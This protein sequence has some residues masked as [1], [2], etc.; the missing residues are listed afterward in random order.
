MIEQNILPFK[1]EVS[2]ENLTAHA[3]LILAHEFH[4]GLA[5]DRLLDEHLPPPG[6]G[7]GHR[8]SEVILPTVLMLQGGGTDLEDI[9]VIGR[10]KTLRAA[11]KLERVPAST[12]LGD[13]L[14]RYGSSPLAMRGLQ[15][16]HRELTA[17]RLNAETRDD[18]TLDIDATIIE[19]HKTDATKAYDG[20]KGYHPMLGFL[21][22]NRWLLAD[23]FRTGSASPS[24]GLV[25]FIE[26]CRAQMPKGKR[27]ARLR[28]DSA[29]YN[30]YVVDYCEEHRIEYVI[31][32]AWD[33]SVKELYK[34]LPRDSWTRYVPSGSRREREVAETI[35]TFNLGPSSFRIIFVRDVDPQKELFGEIRGRAIVTNVSDE[36]MDAA[37]VVEWY[38][39]RGTAENF[40]KEI[41]MGF[42]LLRVPCGQFEANAA[43]L[44]IAALAYNLFLLLQHLALPPDLARSS[45][46]TVRWQL[47][48][49][50]GRMV[51]HARQW[52]LK[53]AADLDVF[54]SLQ[55]MRA[56]ARS[57]AFI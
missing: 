21:F 52:V 31:G 53:V 50:A 3:G 25:E 15:R 49:T 39:Q 27:I 36:K 40:I 34:A 12:T 7:R 55:Q 44:R 30:H 11:A 5:V 47:Y 18:F 51:R 14:R 42:G 20:T 19:A 8:A 37:D 24:G 35:H 2:K 56:A 1:L 45:V 10:D 22:E 33:S 13:C 4:L 6:S 26:Q 41:K 57:C 38:N 46:T 32:A 28:S 9:R 23:Q 29:A 48:Q 16:V 17:T 54:A 43:W